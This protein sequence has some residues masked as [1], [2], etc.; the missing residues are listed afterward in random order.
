M[1]T[2]ADPLLPPRENDSAGGQILERML[3]IILRGGKEKADLHLPLR[4]T[5]TSEAGLESAESS[6]RKVR[7]EKAAGGRAGG[8]RRAGPGGC[9]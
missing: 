9:R 8:V 5:R 3:R 1:T 6:W 4:H 7:R 2:K